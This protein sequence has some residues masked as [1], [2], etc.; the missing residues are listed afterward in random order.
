MRNLDSDDR[1]TDK[2]NKPKTSREWL[3]PQPLSFMEV[4]VIW[5]H[6]EVCIWVVSCIE[7]W[8][9]L[10]IFSMFPISFL[11]FIISIHSTNFVF[12]IHFLAF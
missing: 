8:L 11:L 2:L 3:E 6:F 10:N 7:K 1:V 5:W 4:T 12:A 9:V